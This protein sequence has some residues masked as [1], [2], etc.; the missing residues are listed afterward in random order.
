MRYY[1][2]PRLFSP[3]RNRFRRAGAIIVPTPGCTWGRADMQA[4]ADRPVDVLR[5]QGPGI[6]SGTRTARVKRDRALCVDTARMGGQL[7]GVRRHKVWCQLKREG[8]DV[9]RCTVER[10]MRQLEIQ[11]VRRGG[12]RWTTVRDETLPQP[13]DRVN[14]H[15]AATR[16]AGY[17]WLISR[18][19]PPGRALFTWR[20]S[21]M[22]LPGASWAGSVVPCVPPGTGCAG[23]G[24]VVTAWHQRVDSVTGTTAA[25]ISRWYTERLAAAGIEASA[26]SVGDSYDN[27]LAETIIGLYKTEVIRKRGPWKTLD[28]VNMRPWNGWIGSI[29]VV[30]WHLLAT[31][32]RLSMNRCTMMRITG[33]AKQHDKPT[34]LRDS[35]SGSRVLNY[36]PVCVGVTS[37]IF[38]IDLLGFQQFVDQ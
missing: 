1:V 13:A 27:A 38:P 20:L 29:I 3:K 36:Q 23:A 31:C 18:L 5:A 16:P 14:R 6:G 8:R 26:G 11:G 34:G 12:K 37:K 4:I 9:A 21:W 15:F 19:W 25:S 17:G 2:R 35:R 30:C 32:H 22:C 7:P 10:L 28:D 24:P 33:H